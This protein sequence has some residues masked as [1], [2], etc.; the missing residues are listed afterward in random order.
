MQEI[1]FAV[2][3]S[4][5]CTSQPGS[6]HRSHFFLRVVIVDIRT[7]RC[8]SSN[9]PLPPQLSSFHNYLTPYWIIYIMVILSAHNMLV[10]I[11]CV[12]IGIRLVQQ[13]SVECLW[14][15]DPEQRPLT[16]VPMHCHN[17]YLW[18]PVKPCKLVEIA[19]ESWN[20][21]YAENYHTEE[22]HNEES[23]QLGVRKG[24]AKSKKGYWC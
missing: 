9:F 15:K 11:S 19:G 23:R 13:W 1:I 6:R 24:L 4:W 18:R 21:Q 20:I 12:Y 17:R 22:K 16:S 8:L 3:L 5:R 7:V 14:Q 2:S 10:D